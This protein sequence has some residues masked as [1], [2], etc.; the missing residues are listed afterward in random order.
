MHNDIPDIPLNNGNT[1]PQL[2][3]G[4]FQVDN[5]QDTKDSI[6]WALDAGYRHIDTAKLYGNEQWVGE[7]IRES[8]IPRED[9]FVTSK[10]WNDVRGYDETKTEFQAT[11]D[12]LGFDYLD[13][14]LIHWPAP[15][16]VD[17]WKAMEDLYKA[18]KIKNIG[19][20]NFVPSQLEDL[21]SQT[22][23]KPAVDQI[24]T[25]PYFQQTDLH[26]YLEK[27]GIVH[28]SWSPLGGGRNNA[29]NDPLIQ[30]LAKDH[31]VTPAQIVLRW[32]VERN[33]VVI[34]KSIHEDRVRQNR[35][36]FAFGLDEAEMAEIAKLDQGKRVGPDPENLDWLKKSQEK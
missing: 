4:V 26:A 20:S 24:E 6:K 12:R 19:V 5:A 28:E 11:L 9:I 32:H 36:I 22:E 1:I 7:A 33:E 29:I 34:P 17:N 10:I 25:H 3:L 13:M 23:I 21:M 8:G 2:G 27:Q 30:K 15:G 16:Y 18:G 14:Y 31:N 35:D